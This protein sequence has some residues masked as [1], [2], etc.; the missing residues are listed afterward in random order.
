VWIGFQFLDLI[1]HHFCCFVAYHSC[2]TAIISVNN[3]TGFRT[4]ATRVAVVFEKFPK[5]RIC[6]CI[7]DRHDVS[8]HVIIGI[9][10]DGKFFLFGDYFA[11][12]AAPLPLL[13]QETPEEERKEKPRSSIGNKRKIATDADEPRRWSGARN[14]VPASK[15]MN[16]VAKLITMKRDDEVPQTNFDHTELGGDYL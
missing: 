8:N 14:P 12:S 11:T 13:I 4:A 9:L 7:A 1:A 3:K 6:A 10:Q 2:N 5:M 16:V 15:P